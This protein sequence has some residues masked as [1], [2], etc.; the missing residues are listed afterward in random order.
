LLL[1]SR[2]PVECYGKISQNVG[3]QAV[4]GGNHFLSS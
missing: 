2:L 4:D 1:R 3:R